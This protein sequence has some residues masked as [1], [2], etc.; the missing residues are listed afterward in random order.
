MARNPSISSMIANINT[1]KKTSFKSYIDLD[2]KDMNNSEDKECVN[3]DEMWTTL[4]E[5]GVTTDLSKIRRNSW[6]PL[7][8]KDR[9]VMTRS[10]SS[11]GS[12]MNDTIDGVNYFYSHTRHRTGICGQL[13]LNTNGLMFLSYTSQEP[14][15]NNSK[16]STNSLNNFIPFNNEK[17]AI[18]QIDLLAIDDIKDMNDSNFISM[19]IFCW[20]LRSIRFQMKNCDQTR[21]I[22]DKLRRL[23]THSIARKYSKLTKSLRD[24]YSY[25]L[26]ADW[27]Q[28]EGHWSECYKLR[29]TQCNENYQLC[30]SLSQTFVVPK[31]LTDQM[32][33]SLISTQTRGQRVPVVSYIYQKNG[34]LLLRSSAFDNYED[35]N[36]L[37]KDMINP[38]RQMTIDNILPPLVVVEQCYDKLRETCFSSQFGGQSNGSLSKIGK[39]IYYVCSALKVVQNVVYIIKN[40]SSVGLVEEFDR[41]W[42]CVI[43]SLVQIM[44]DPKRRTFAG[45]ESLISKEWLYL[46]GLAFRK[47]GAINI[48]HILFTLF[49][50]CVSQLIIQNPYAF[51]FSTFYLIYLF[52]CQYIQIVTPFLP[53][54]RK[55][56]TKIGL[57]FEPKCGQLREGLSL[58]ELM[59][60]K[61]P[62]FRRHKPIDTKSNDLKLNAHISQMHFWSMLYL[63]WQSTPN[64]EH[65][66]P[67]EII[68]LNEL[69]SRNQL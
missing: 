60:I 61:N 67:F 20:S 28:L 19:T 68:L 13:T 38:L 4:D 42:N 18:F 16:T 57:E 40:E 34:N 24:N 59:L 58:N 46:P 29:L 31:A 48:N 21:R 32:L 69:Q 53:N 27:I 8:S 41:E 35:L 44:I 9:R 47:T 45:F 26:K 33:I 10:M 3:T 25:I 37:L 43:S 17:N 6:L 66:S 7:D 55:T 54:A 12:L 1:N 36:S 11:I 52:D 63:R 39:W 56:S 51:E 15:D 64:L 22:V 30:D 2:I 65:L 5:N 62:V 49:L 50:D 23:T 14:N